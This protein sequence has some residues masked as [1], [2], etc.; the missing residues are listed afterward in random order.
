MPFISVKSCSRATNRR[1]T[2]P[3]NRATLSL[4]RLGWNGQSG[5]TYNT[6]R[7]GSGLEYAFNGGPLS[8]SRWVL[9]TASRTMSCG[10]VAVYRRV[11]MLP[12]SEEL[13]SS[14]KT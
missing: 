5:I 9:T 7:H 4:C 6:V 13:T 2:E 14:K 11:Y 10:F 12:C 1:I 3:V 8:S